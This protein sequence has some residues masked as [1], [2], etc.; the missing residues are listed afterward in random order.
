MAAGMLIN[1]ESSPPLL[2]HRPP[3]IV[4][5]GSISLTAFSLT[6]RIRQPARF[7]S[8]LV[9][10]GRPFARYRLPHLP[11]AFDSTAA[12]KSPEVEVITRASF[13]HCIPS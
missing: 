5:Y 3:G 13:A 7:L 1:L 8:I 12:E 2:H 4:T 9:Y 10:V 11:R 6:N